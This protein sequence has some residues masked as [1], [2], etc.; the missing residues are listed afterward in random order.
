MQLTRLSSIIGIFKLPHV[1]RPCLK[2]VPPFFFA[3]A[4][5]FATGLLVSIAAFFLPPGE[6]TPVKPDGIAAWA[7]IVLLCLFTGYWEEG[8]FRMYFLTICRRA[9]IHR[10]FAALFSSF[11]FASCHAYE[12]IPGMIN[13]G[14]AGILLSAIYLKTESYHGLA[15]AHTAY[16]VM[17]FIIA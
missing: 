8:L 7:K 16:N 5:L 12:G 14:L 1:G 17:V 11:V 3:L 2:D 9:G 15:L 13:A 6:F 4:G 10:Y